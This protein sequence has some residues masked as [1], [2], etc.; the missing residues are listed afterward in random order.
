MKAQPFSHQK[1]K[2]EMGGER[3]GDGV[4]D[5]PTAV[6]KG[7]YFCSQGKLQTEFVWRQE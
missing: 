7:A 5:F 2:A 6:T 4:W 3:G 1:Q